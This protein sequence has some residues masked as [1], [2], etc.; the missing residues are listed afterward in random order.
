MEDIL[1]DLV[2]RIKES[3]D[4]ITVASGEIAAGN[5]NLSQ[6]TDEQASSLKR[7]ASSME[8]L[9]ATVRQNAERLTTIVAWSLRTTPRPSVATPVAWDEID[10]AVAARDARTL[11]F[12]PAEALSRAIR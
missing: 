10:R 3:T 12:G 2:T 8:E 7:T 11:V 5:A 6:R 4:P 9:T 1:T